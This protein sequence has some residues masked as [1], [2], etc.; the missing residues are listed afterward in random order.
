[1]DEVLKK[2]EN[3]MDEVRSIKGDVKVEVEGIKKLLDVKVNDID[4]Y[5]MET[6]TKVEIQEEKVNTIEK[7]RRTNN[8]VIYNLEETPNE[9]W[10]ELMRK[11]NLLFNTTMK[12][13][14]KK[15]EINQYFR[16]GKKTGRT[17]NRPVLVKM[18]NHW[19]KMEIL[20]N[21]ATLKGTKIFLSQDLTQEEKQEKKVLLEKVKHIRNTGKHAVLKGWKIFVEGHLF[22]E[23]NNQDDS[24]NNMNTEEIMETNYPNGEDTR[25]GKNNTDNWKAPNTSQKRDLSISPESNHESREKT[26]PIAGSIKKHRK[27]LTARSNSAP[28]LETQTRL[29]A[30][31]DFTKNLETNETIQGDST[32]EINTETPEN[33][34]TVEKNK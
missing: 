34:T 12:L 27:T 18:V 17:P 20:R 25:E 23:T 29:D 16:M 6:R 32:E 15:D 33:T 9:T 21:T 2:M 8:I 26:K 10:E 14:V 1:M 13:N 31:L 7:D 11:I 28:R 4:K 19:K 5:A 3:M 24:D 22:K 30:F